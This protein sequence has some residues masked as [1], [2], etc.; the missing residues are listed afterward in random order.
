MFETIRW[1]CH[2]RTHDRRGAERVVG[3]LAARLDRTIRFET[4]ERYGK[5]P[6]LAEVRLTSPLETV[7]PEATLL[8]VLHSAWR[9][10]TPWVLG[11]PGTDGE[12]DGIAAANTGS[13]FTVP[14]IEWME[15]YV[16]DR[17]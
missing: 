3:R 1:R 6:E 14:G 15:F 17:R 4:Y 13:R 11:A 5:Y 2:V 16:T 10:A 12:F 7:S 9:I 8:T